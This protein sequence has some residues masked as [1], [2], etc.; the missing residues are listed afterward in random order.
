MFDQFADFIQILLICRLLPT[1][2]TGVGRGRATPPTPP[3]RSRRR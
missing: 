3:P 2:I 1:E